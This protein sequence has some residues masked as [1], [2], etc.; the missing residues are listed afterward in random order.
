MSIDEKVS[1]IL[2]MLAVM[3]LL[4]C[5]IWKRAVATPAPE[6][7]SVPNARDT[8]GMSNTPQNSDVT[9]G[10]RYLMYNTRWAFPV[11]VNPMIFPNT[12]PGITPSQTS[13]WIG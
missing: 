4:A 7:A 13:G 8:V 1:H 9:Q 10:P 11:S 2:L 6:V 12:N 3:G 5:L